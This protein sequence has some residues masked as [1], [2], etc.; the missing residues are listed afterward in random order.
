MPFSL[1]LPL[2][3]QWLDGSLG[4]STSDGAGEPPHGVR[5]LWISGVGGLWRALLTARELWAPSVH[6]MWSKMQPPCAPLYVPWW[7]GKM[8]R[9]GQNGPAVVWCDPGCALGQPLH[10]VRL[11]GI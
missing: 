2:P 8:E 1:S 7:V 5:E 9:E 11:W 3:L 10:P 6:P 4:N